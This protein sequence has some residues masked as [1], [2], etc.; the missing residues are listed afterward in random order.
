MS[1]FGDR[2]NNLKKKID[3]LEQLNS[4]KDKKIQEL[5]DE[6]QNKVNGFCPDLLDKKDG[7]IK[8]K[9]KELKEIKDQLILVLNERDSIRDDISKKIDELNK[10]DLSKEEKTEQISK[11]MTGDYQKLGNACQKTTQILKEWGR[12]KDGLFELKK[13]IANSRL[14]AIQSLEKTKNRQ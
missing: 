2:I 1:S 4:L 7:E 14:E 5:N 12:S 8:I 9:E 6:L 3:T 10:S 13:M 11:L